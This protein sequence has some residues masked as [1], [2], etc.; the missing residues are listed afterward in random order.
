M[1]YTGS[2]AKLLELGGDDMMLG[3]VW[4]GHNY[5]VEFDLNDADL[6]QLRQMAMDE[7]LINANPDTQAEAWAPI[8][9]L[10]AIG[11]IGTEAATQTLLDFLH[12]LRRYDFISEDISE[13]F[14]VIGPTAIPHLSAYL[15]DTERDEMHRSDASY[16]L[17][18]LGHRYPDARPKI[19][20]ILTAQ[21]EHYTENGSDLNTTII[22]ILTDWQ[23]TE[24]LSLIETA[25]R[26]GHVEEFFMD[27][28]DVQVGMGLKDS[29]DTPAPRM[30]TQPNFNPLLDD[31][32]EQAERDSVESP[33]NPDQETDANNVHGQEG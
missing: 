19:V 8:H 25:Y 5:A 3:D 32:Q 13:T 14:S 9:A 4:N 10:R 11:F 17:A 18:A 1:T 26:E 22:G 30:L 29:R 15:A 28:E 23:V 6:P 27:W 16:A 2:V 20:K 31:L 21:L 12:E 24:T 33:Q 7:A